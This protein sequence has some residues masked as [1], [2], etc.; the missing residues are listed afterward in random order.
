[1]KKKRKF[2]RRKLFKKKKTKILKNQLKKVY[3]CDNF[4]QE[5]CFYIITMCDSQKIKIIKINEEKIV[6]VLFLGLS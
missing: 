1:M 2:N 4:V 6:F 3:E 5:M